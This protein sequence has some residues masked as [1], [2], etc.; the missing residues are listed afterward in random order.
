MI[1]LIP[2][3]IEGFN[4]AEQHKGR[5]M[6]IGTLS[7][8][9]V[10]RS[11]SK[12]KRKVTILLFDYNNAPIMYRQATGKWQ[13]Q[14][15]EESDTLIDRSFLYEDNQGREYYRKF[16]NS[17]QIFLGINNRFYL[18]LT[19]E[20]VESETLH[21]ILRLFPLSAFLQQTDFTNAKHR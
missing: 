1:E 20:G 12:N 13:S 7:Y 4:L 3:K 21:A 18:M 16:T 6:K 14:P 17:S 9:M 5:M 19:G 15:D 2:K 11:F 10:E 8:S